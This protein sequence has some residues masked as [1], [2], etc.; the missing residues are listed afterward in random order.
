MGKEAIVLC[1]TNT[2][3]HYF[4]NHQPTIDKVNSIG[5]LNVLLSSITIMELYRGM[6]NKKELK[7]MQK[8]IKGYSVMNFN[9]EI[10][11]L[12]IELITDFK[13]SHDLKIPDAIIGASAIIYNIPLFTYNKKDFKFMPGITLYS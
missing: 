5:H 3:I 13:L 2:L 12:A 6:G 11:M 1:D 8:K 9:A 10:S 4:N 7:E